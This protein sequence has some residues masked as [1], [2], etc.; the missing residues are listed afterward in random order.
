MTPMTRTKKAGIPLSIKI[1]FMVGGFR[2]VRQNAPIVRM[3]VS[4]D[5]DPSEVSL[6]SISG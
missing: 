6:I 3:D 2:R 4:P 1:C 5:Y